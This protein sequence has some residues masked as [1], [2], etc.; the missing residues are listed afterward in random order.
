M[1]A[2]KVAVVC[3]Y[4]DVGKGRCTIDGA[5]GA[6]VIITE[7]NPI[8]ALQAAMAGY[9]WT[10]E[11]YAGQRRYLCNGN[12]KYRII[13]AE[14]MSKMKDQAIVCKSAIL[15]MKFRWLSSKSMGGH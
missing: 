7:I 11:K 10:I 5:M 14:H 1:I 8:C 9:K 2:G 12:R 3:G 15:I 4:G 13:T 6:R